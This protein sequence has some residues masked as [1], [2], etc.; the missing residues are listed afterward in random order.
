ME[1]QREGGDTDGEGV[2]KEIGGQGKKGRPVSTSLMKMKHIVHGR[3]VIIP[4]PLNISCPD[5]NAPL[6]Y[7]TIA[8]PCS[9]CLQRE[10]QIA[11]PHIGAS[12]S[13]EQ[14]LEDGQSQML[15]LWTSGCPL[16]GLP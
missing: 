16:G 5:E 9:S 2:G 14:T 12:W 13:P 4:G 10:M 3:C 15:P 6:W 7:N 8:F 11:T 1:G